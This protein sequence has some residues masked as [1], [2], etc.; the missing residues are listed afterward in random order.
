ML[1]LLLLPMVDVLHHP[2]PCHV[3]HTELSSCE[4]Y[5]SG[6]LLSSIQKEYN[7]LESESTYLYPQVEGW[8]G[9]YSIGS[10]KKS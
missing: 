3:L 8:G 6:C 2:Q 4:T 5:V 10:I 7:V 9:K 1:E